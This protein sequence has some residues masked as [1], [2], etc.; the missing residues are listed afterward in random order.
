[1]G[2]I[3]PGAPKELTLMIKRLV[4][5]QTFVETGTAGGTPPLGWPAHWPSF[6]QVSKALGRQSEPSYILVLDDVILQ[7]PARFRRPVELYLPGLNA[8]GSFRRVIGRLSSLLHRCLVTG[9]R[10]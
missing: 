4:G 3:H 8:P 6:E 1:M 10:K 5:A 2:L 9:R 7:L